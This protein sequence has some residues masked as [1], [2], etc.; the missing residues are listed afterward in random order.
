[1]TVSEAIKQV[2]SSLPEEEATVES[3]VSEILESRK[4]DRNELIPILQQVQ[5]RLGYLPREAMSLIARFLDVPESTVFGVATFY[6]QFKFVPTGRTAIRVCRGNACHARGGKRILREAETRLG[7]KPG[8]STEDLEYALESVP[9]L[10][11]CSVSPV[12]VTGKETHGHMTPK[13]LTEILDST[14]SGEE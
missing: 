2:P 14:D 1:M 8:E 4:G 3:Q 5:D 10:G 9:C 11:L 6:S 13:K 12:V 7:I